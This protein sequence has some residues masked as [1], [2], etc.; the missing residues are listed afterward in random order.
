ML[1]GTNPSLTEEAEWKL[2][3]RSNQSIVQDFGRF[4]V[5]HLT[6]PAKEGVADSL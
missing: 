4:P 2:T 1:R 5:T 6:L 3:I